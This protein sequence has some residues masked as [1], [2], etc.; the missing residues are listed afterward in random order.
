MRR[1]RPLILA[2]ALALHG[3]PPAAAAELPPEFARVL[4]E[5]QQ[6]L[7]RLEARNAELER[8]LSSA[9]TP[10]TPE[11]ET[12][13][14]A[15]EA[16]NTRLTSA[17]ESDRL[18]QDDPE[19]AMRLKAVEFQALGMQKQART[20]EALEG[21][22]AG[23]SFTSV[24]QHA[25]A[26]ATS[27]GKTASELSWRGDA[28]ISLPGGTMG[29]SEGNLFF[30]FR[31][32]QGNGLTELNQQFSSPNATTF[33]LD[34]KSD[35]ASPILA[36]AWYQLNMPLD[37]RPL[38][39]SREQL[40]LNFGKLDPFLFFDQNAAADDETVK[41]MNLAFVHNPLLDAG[42]AAGLDSYGF[43]PGLRLAYQNTTQA[44]IGWGVSL[45]VFGSDSGAVFDDSLK[46]PFTILQA[47]TSQRMLGGLE[48]NYRVYAWRNGRATD[49]AE[50]GL[51][52][53]SG[54]GLSLDQRIG[55][56]MTLFGRY[57]QTMSGH[58]AF[59]RALTVGA[60]FSGNY[61]DRGADSMGLALGWLAAADAYRLANPDTSG[62]EQLAELYYRWRMNKQFELSPDY[63]FVRRAGADK[64][65]SD[66]H[67]VG[68]RA[69]L[70][71]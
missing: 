29:N 64:A 44:P 4:Q 35:D 16:A 8:R 13:I 42:G 51:E 33:R 5:M 1:I 66:A 49:F 53:Q 52:V 39:R 56:G 9:D 11:I 23:V 24:A 37:E 54:W 3:G 27:T 57:G 18:S 47:E 6:R 46:K 28:Q 34:G 14:Q 30:H 20:I 55:D 67:I 38:N 68:L 65:V 41:F 50:T 15:L 62:H 61:W 32:G 70:T 21:I 69:Q 10:A 22:S 71:F 45:G 17:M 2:L 12:R 63:Q 48:G 19:I 40:K 58:P 31:M 26:G 25:N 43:S 60:E 59:D 7:T 36:Q